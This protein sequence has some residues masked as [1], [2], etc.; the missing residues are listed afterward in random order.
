MTLRASLLLAGWTVLAGIG[1]PLVGVLNSGLARAVGN[2]VSAT[3]IMFAVAFVVAATIALPMHG[4]PTIR[5]LSAAPIG[6]YAAGLI[7]GFYALSAT[8]II[9]RF[10]AGSFVTFILLAQL[11]T[12]AVIDQWG[13]FGIERRPADA[14]KL[15]A[16][17][18]IV[19][20][21][22]LMQW[23]GRRADG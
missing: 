7:M 3:A 1:I 16:F 2:A 19:S 21:I 14:A 18:L 5:Q 12:A 8:I 20:G 13:L 10:G 22:V 11:L 4:V 17:A 23:S 6:S 15:V 9:P